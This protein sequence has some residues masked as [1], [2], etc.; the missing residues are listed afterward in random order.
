MFSHPDSGQG[1]QQVEPFDLG[2]LVDHI[3]NLES[4]VQQLV[5]VSTMWQFRARQLEDQLKQ[6]AAGEIVPQMV[7]EPP[8]STETSGTGL[9][10]LLDRVRRLWGR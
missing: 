7:P 4:Q 1:R 2:P 5:E 9:R 3:A 10:G 6:L 8:G